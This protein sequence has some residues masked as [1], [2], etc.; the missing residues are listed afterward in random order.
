MIRI[1][2]TQIDESHAA[3][4]ERFAEQRSAPMFLAHEGFLGVL[5]ARNGADCAVITLWETADA[6][7]ALDSSPLYQQTTRDIM[8]TGFIRL[9]G[10]VEVFCSHGVLL[11]DGLQQQ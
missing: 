11:S 1:W 9:E 5:F 8:A 4:Y 10:S 7:H 2:R 6:A 3:E